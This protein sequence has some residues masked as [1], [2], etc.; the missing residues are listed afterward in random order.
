MNGQRREGA[1]KVPPVVR[2]GEGAGGFSRWI[3]AAVLAGGLYF[4]GDRLGWPDDLDARYSQWRHKGPTRLAVIPKT[5]A[6]DLET[7]AL[8]ASERADVHWVM[9]PGNVPYLAPMR[10]ALIAAMRGANWEDVEASALRRQNYSETR[11]PAGGPK[12]IIRPGAVI[13]V[14]TAEG[15]LAK[16]RM[17]KIHANNDLRA[18][19]LLYKE[20]PGGQQATRRGAESNPSAAWMQLRD[21]A[22][23]A[24]RQR[25]YHE[26]Q[27]LCDAAISEAEK[28]APR[29]PRIAAAL[30]GCG[31]LPGFQ[32]HAPAQAEAWLRRAAALVEGMDHQRI[33]SALGP[34]EAFLKQRVHRAL[35]VMY[36]DR[37]RPREAAQHFERAVEAVRAMP[38]P[39]SERHFTTMGLDFYELGVAHYRS[40]NTAAARTAFAEAKQML[41]RSNPEHPVLAAIARYEQ[42]LDSLPR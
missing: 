18:E 14:R 29:D 9:T 35:G 36:R 15:N 5:G 39:A 33:V 37:R 13:A 6:I 40:R 2:T 10:G 3:I 8:G 28:V 42:Q 19:W 21:E 25:R 31:G 27:Q 7:G 16:L 41:Q 23:R 34:S 32:R 24:Y 11:L 1:G 38:S 20:A 4:L 26:V 17:V 22:R 12:A 30:L